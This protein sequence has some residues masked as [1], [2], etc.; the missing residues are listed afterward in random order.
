MPRQSLLYAVY[1]KLG[2]SAHP[3]HFSFFLAGLKL[4]LGSIGAWA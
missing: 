3:G 4:L 2:I 1:Y